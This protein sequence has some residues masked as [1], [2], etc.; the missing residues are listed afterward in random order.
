MNFVKGHGKEIFNDDSLRFHEKSNPKLIFCK[1]EMTAEKKK[2]YGTAG[3]QMVVLQISK[4]VIKGENIKV[5]YRDSE[6]K[7]IG[8]PDTYTA[9]RSGV[10]SSYLGASLYRDSR[11][12]LFS[13]GG[14]SGTDQYKTVDKPQAKK[15]HFIDKL[16][17]FVE[18]GEEISEYHSKEENEAAASQIDDKV[19]TFTRHMAKKYSR[20]AKK[21]KV[22]QDPGKKQEEIKDGPRQKNPYSIFKSSNAEF[23]DKAEKFSD[24][25]GDSFRE[26]DMDSRGNPIFIK[27]DVLEADDRKENPAISQKDNYS[28]HYAPDD[29]KGYN[30]HRQKDINGT[31]N[32]GNTEEG[33]KGQPK[34]QNRPRVSGNED[35]TKGNND[36]KK[37]AEKNINSYFNNDAK[38]ETK[39]GQANE[40][41]GEKNK[42]FSRTKDGEVQKEKKRKL[43]KAAATT[44]LSRT[45][46]VK[47]EIQNQLGDMSGQ[48]SGDLLKDGNNGLLKAVTDGIQ[49][50]ATN[51][52]RKIAVKFLIPAALILSIP[53]LL[54]FAVFPVM[55]GISGGIVALAGSDSDSGED[56]D[57]APLG[58]DGKTRSDLS[59]SDIDTII[60]RL[61]TKYP[62]DMSPKQEQVLRYAL[63][64]VGCRY[65]QNYH[66]SL[67]ADIFDC[68]S[69]AF[70]AYREAGI[71]IANGGAYS[72]AEECRAMEN[73]NRVVGNDLRPGDLIFYGGSD[74]G[75]YKGIYHVAIYVGDGK[76]VE[77]KGKNAGVVYGDVRTENVVV[78]ARPLM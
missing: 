14:S 67:T 71:N 28:A 40:H 18:K 63:S 58:G 17:K 49:N 48:G 66:G 43:K 11:W 12:R 25:Y 59:R 55:M 7:Q 60:T 8:N 73:K 41:F 77:A 20:D 1:K 9:E 78:C 74:N 22:E 52:K 47:K 44:A 6:P 21:L 76:M 51:I 27:K 29:S 62:E 37:N 32:N 4:K 34:L 54:I 46:M 15:E 50:I 69:L 61:Y 13:T 56:Y 5:R 38:E 33:E 23:S 42:V 64:K 36:G 65:D 24:P 72:A 75:R 19:I 16:Q 26:R 53:L 2:N 35:Y 70:R 31:N 39:T 30:E 68:S 3:K 57:L 10:G 45:F